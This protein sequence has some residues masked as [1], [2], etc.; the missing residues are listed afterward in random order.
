VPQ[1]GVHPLVVVRQVSAASAA[2]ERPAADPDRP[3]ADDE[4][5]QVAGEG[6]LA[7]GVVLLA[8]ATGQP[9]LHRPR[10]RIA[11]SRLAQGD[12]RGHREPGRDGELRGGRRLGLQVPAG[13]DGVGALQ[14]EPRSEPV[15][16][17]EDGVV[18]AGGGNAADVQSPPLRKLRADQVAR[19]GGVDEM[20][21]G[22]HGHGG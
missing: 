10:Q 19:H 3:D 20:F 15:T 4:L 5:R 14:G 16:E 1:A 2:G 6:H 8:R 9:G 17:A 13:R 21:A 18:R 12:D 22:V 7:G 11:G